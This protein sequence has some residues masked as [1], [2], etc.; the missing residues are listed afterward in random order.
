MI[1]LY[2]YNTVKFPA[3]E[4]VNISSSPTD[5]RGLNITGTLL[6]LSRILQVLLHKCND[7]CCLQTYLFILQ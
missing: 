7:Y 4:I 1:M 2:V 6:C 5:K 3:T